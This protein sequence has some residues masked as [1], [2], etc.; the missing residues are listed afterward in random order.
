MK[1]IVE[2][3]LNGDGRADFRIVVHI[4]T[5]DGAPALGSNAHLT[6]DDFIL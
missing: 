2:G 1:G 4:E 3:D 5:E 6:A